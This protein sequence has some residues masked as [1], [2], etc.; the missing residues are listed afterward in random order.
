[1]PEDRKVAGPTA[2]IEEEFPLLAQF[3]QSNRD[4]LDFAVFGVTI[5]GGDFKDE[6]GFKEAS[7]AKD[8]PLSG[9]YVVHDI[10]PAPAKEGDM[11]LPVA[12]ALGLQ[13]RAGG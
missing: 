6:P 5:A 10:G 13:P 1:V 8:N 11:T 7:L 2:Y 4:L 9:G 3:L 12:W